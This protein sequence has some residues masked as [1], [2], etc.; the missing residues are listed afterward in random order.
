MGDHNP[1]NSAD[2]RD[3]A[4]LL[5]TE[6]AA[7]EYWRSVAEQRRSAAATVQR[8]P[9]VRAAIALDRRSEPLQN[10]AQRAAARL[11]TWGDRTRLR[12]MAVPTVRSLGERRRDLH[13]Q[14]VRAESTH[15]KPVRS[16]D[17][18]VVDLEQA[19][20]MG[21][22][23]L[24]SHT[25]RAPLVGPDRRRPID[26][27]AVNLLVEGCQPDAICVLAPEV[28]PLSATWIQ[29]LTQALSRDVAVSVPTLVHP[30]RPGHRTPHDLLT[31][32]RGIVIETIGGA[33]QPR[34]L[35]AG[36]GVDVAA[37]STEPALASAACAVIA[38]DAWREVGGLVVDDDADAALIDLSLRIV[39]AGHHI[40]GLAEVLV[41][42]RRPVESP[43][44]LL[45]EI[46]PDSTAWS[47]AIAHHGPALRRH[48]AGHKSDG[49]DGTPPLSITLTT[50]VPSAKLIATWGDWN[51]ASGFAAALRRA[52]HPTTLQTLAEVEDPAAR[53][54][55]VQVVLRGLFPAPRSPGQPHVLWVISHPEAITADEYDRADLVLIASPRFAD[56]VRSLTSTPVEVFLQATD[57]E[58]FKLRSATASRPHGVLIVANSRGVRRRVVTDSDAAGI[59]YSIVGE[60]WEKIVPSERIIAD[61][62]AY[63]DLPDLY[64]ATDLVL[65]DHWDTMAG[66]GFV[67][68]R[69]LDVLACGT[70]V[71]SDHLPELEEMFGDLVP[72]WETA[73]ELAALVEDRR[74][75]PETWEKR[76]LTAR[77]L[78]LAHHTFDHRARELTELLGRHG[79]VSRPGPR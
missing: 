51:F 46:S 9:I 3:V 12:T 75:D 33:P 16:M 7:T 41:T 30:E 61:H 76:A 25:G 79:L 38:G 28:A 50:S 17:V 5:A 71:V 70:P 26:A 34:S 11:R 64:S 63:P 31:R 44:A 47:S 43:R 10:R 67:S 52:G 62:V 36:D 1:Q 37:P 19:T 39:A 78:V 69:V 56:H 27:G 65:N 4:R 6:R 2:G 42:D 53:S 58:H 18:L 23:E 77:D 13:T 48:A 45:C 35:G 22:A 49:T 20:A 24:R 73:A 32:S 14:M 8:R 72:T 60:G 59:D 55:D 40:R 21:V 54:N 74:A 66:W 29:R 15:V 68:N 57:P